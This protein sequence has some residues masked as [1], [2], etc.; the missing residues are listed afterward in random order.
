MTFLGIGE[1]D[2]ALGS[3]RLM[4]WACERPYSRPCSS[5]GFCSLN[6]LHSSLGALD[7]VFAAQ[8]LFREESTLLKLPRVYKMKAGLSGS[9]GQCLG[10]CVSHDSCHVE[11]W[12]CVAAL[13][14]FYLWRRCLRL[15]RMLKGNCRSLGVKSK[16]PESPKGR[17]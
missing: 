8:T 14:A 15:M 2:K 16:L 10:L 5:P 12:V 1:E 4:C 6:C 13:L 11:R 7:V 17:V 9:Q 3:P